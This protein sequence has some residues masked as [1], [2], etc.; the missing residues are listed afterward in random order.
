MDQESERVVIELRRGALSGPGVRANAACF[1]VEL[2]PPP[3]I[4]RVQDALHQAIA[5]ELTVE[6]LFEPD[7]LS[8]DGSDLACYVVVEWPGASFDDVSA[9]P[10]ALARQIKD[11]LGAEEVVPDIETP[12][13][14]PLESAVSGCWEDPSLEPKD[15]GWALRAIR[16]DKAWAF[17]SK[18]KR[19]IAGEGILI[20]QPDTGVNK[21][22][23]LVKGLQVTGSYD[24][25]DKKPVPIDP[26]VKEHDL[27]TPG[28]G[29]ATASVV[30]SRGG[31]NEPVPNMPSGTTGPGFV[32]GAAT[33]AQV[34]PIRAIR[35]VVRLSQTS[36]VRAI[37]HARRAGC[38]VITMSL[39]GVYSRALEAAVERAVADN[40]IV[41]AAAG[42]CVRLVVY[43]ARLSS[44]I[45]VAATNI[46][47]HP[48]RGTCRGDSVDISAPGEFVWR[49]VRKTPDDATDQVAG[50]QGTSFAVALVAGVAACW[51]AHHGREKL[52]AASPNGATLQDLFRHHLQATARTPEGWDAT[53]F[54]A[55]IMDA[56]AL[57]AADAELPERVSRIATEPRVSGLSKSAIQAADLLSDPEAPVSGLQAAGA[58]EGLSVLQRRDFAPELIWLTYTRKLSQL[59][60]GHTARLSDLHQPAET[61][62]AGF[63]ASEALQEVVQ[64][65]DNETLK[66][67]V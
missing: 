13:Y 31:L 12:F 59:A 53:N 21:H 24:F 43:P 62:F 45:A 66:Q 34:M 14:S 55:G 3:D 11:L 49:A 17:S 19:P 64:K 36:V 51:L 50:G 2:R 37:D 23:E 52:I 61:P 35:S 33:S 25:V 20:G 47:D 57:L 6:P 28:H 29:I 44:C 18:Q 7:G 1:I 65:I 30:I 22:Q 63:T 27:D 32:T 5:P 42:N 26:L 48:W 15:I 41:L 54:G 56:E 46:D 60:P 39:G 58:L 9:S 38:Y 10:F 67:L 4:D 16:I 8:A 40:I